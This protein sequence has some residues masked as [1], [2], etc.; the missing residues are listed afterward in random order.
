MIAPPG[1]RRVRPDMPHYGVMPDAVDGM[2]SWDW[3][4][5]RMSVARNYW[6][7]TTRAD[8]QPHAAPVWGAWYSGAFYF[9]TDEN[10]V[11]AAN[12]RRDPRVVMH[13]DSG[14]DVVIF[15]GELSLAQLSAEDMSR[16]DAIYTK[17][18]D[19]SPELETSDSL[20]FQLHPRKV[21]AWRE[22]DFPSSATA[23][24]FD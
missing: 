19:L 24:R 17:K 9:G 21:M 4:A 11:K 18:Y 5:E 15:E 2:L 10:S 8:G 16:L 3:V 20:V 22:K 14:D 12:I 1:A 23:W 13:L 6:L 7:C